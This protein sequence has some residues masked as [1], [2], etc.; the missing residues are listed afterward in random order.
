MKKATILAGTIVVLLTAGCGGESATA[1]STTAP[2]ATAT[3]PPAT[4]PSQ[5]E[6]ATE[7]SQPEACVRFERFG[8]VLTEAD[9]QLLLVLAEKCDAAKKGTP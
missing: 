3:A 9:Y 5:P 4:A 8:P 6:A 2:P 7:P 1:P